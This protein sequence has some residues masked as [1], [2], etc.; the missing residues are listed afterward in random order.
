MGWERAVSGLGE[1]FEL[2][3]SR[4]EEDW[5]RVGRVLGA[6]WEW[7][8]RGLSDVWGCPGLS[9]DWL[10]ETRLCSMYCPRPYSQLLGN[11]TRETSHP[12]PSTLGN[13]GASLEEA[14]ISGN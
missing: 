14:P 7:V 2:A 3:G 12:N 10:G 4:L 13:Q 6:G 5:K 8:G 9:D 1:G 11:Y